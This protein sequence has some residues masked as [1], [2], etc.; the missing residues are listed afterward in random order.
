MV[1]VEETMKIL[2]KV[3]M[4]VYVLVCVGAA[5]LNYNSEYR[6]SILTIG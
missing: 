2:P 4:V 1:E 6:W 5:G 3:S